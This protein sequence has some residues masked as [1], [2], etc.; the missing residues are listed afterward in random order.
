MNVE[1][2]GEEEKIDYDAVPKVLRS[3]FE[4]AWKFARKSVNK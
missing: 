4:E 3:H 2:E 1:G